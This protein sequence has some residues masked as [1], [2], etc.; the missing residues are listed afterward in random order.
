LSNKKTQAGLT[1]ATK[2]RPGRASIMKTLDAGMPQLFF[3]KAHFFLD[4]VPEM[5]QHIPN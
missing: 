2:Q 4:T 5:P 1:A 3:E